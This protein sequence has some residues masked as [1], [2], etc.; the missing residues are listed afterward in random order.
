M[1]PLAPINPLTFEP[2]KP[3]APYPSV[4][5]MPFDPSQL[6][7][8]KFRDRTVVV[9]R[10]RCPDYDVGSFLLGNSQLPSI[11]VIIEMSCL[12]DC[13]AAKIGH[14]RSRAA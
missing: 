2:I 6:L 5:G 8:L 4:T 13:T 14:H 7:P 11:I 9:A 3:V 10:D 12:F 1:M